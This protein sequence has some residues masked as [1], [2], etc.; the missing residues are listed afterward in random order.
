MSDQW[1]PWRS[2]YIRFQEKDVSGAIMR[3]FSHLQWNLAWN[4]RSSCSDIQTTL[5]SIPKSEHIR[6]EETKPMPFVSCNDT[7]FY[8]I[9]YRSSKFA[10]YLNTI[11]RQIWFYEIDHYSINKSLYFRKRLPDTRNDIH[12][13]F[14][15]V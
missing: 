5:S 14:S 9:E 13:H 8:F 7:S 15:P 6:I 11:G 12:R 2:R 3:S 4:K 1:P 10:N